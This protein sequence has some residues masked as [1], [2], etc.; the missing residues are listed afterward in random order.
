[1]NTKRQQILHWQQQ[2]HITNKDIEQSLLV[3][4]TN[5]TPK[6]WFNFISKLLV[7]LSVLAMACGVIFFFAYNWA[8]LSLLA[9]FAL[10][11]GLM[12]IS[13]YIY[14]QTTTQSHASTAI[15][16][17][18]SLLIGSLFALFGQT[19]Q[20]GKD[21]WQLFALWTLFITPLAFTAKKSSLWIMWLALANLGAYLYMEIHFGFLGLVFS[22]E[23]VFLFFALINLLAVLLLESL[24]RFHFI[25]NRIAAQVAVLTSM[26]AFT[27]VAIY[28]TFEYANHSI[29][30]VLYLAWMAGVYFFYR[31]KG[32]DVLL[33]SSWVV[34]GIIF[35]IATFGRMIN[36]D[37]GG[38][39]FLF[40]GLLTLGLSAVGGKWLIKLSQ[41]AHKGDA[42]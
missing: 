8:D 15:L 14:T 18:L 26:F 16:L 23:R 36:H 25:E 4:S 12:I 38:A 30:L 17:F 20:T 1:M 37:F 35:I 39:T 6:Q 22:H 34:S 10:L 2:G 40:L 3:T 19:Y 7:S 28:S 42:P 11:Q 27:G 21:P 32:L 41:E 9:K 13:L 5:N 24:N 31:L 29:D 33:L